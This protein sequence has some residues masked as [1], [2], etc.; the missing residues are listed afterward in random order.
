MF[1]TSAA[2]KLLDTQRAGQLPVSALAAD[3][4]E[5][6]PKLLPGCH[7]GIGDL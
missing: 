7:R 2:R 1:M 4:Q 6:N 5:T 3:F